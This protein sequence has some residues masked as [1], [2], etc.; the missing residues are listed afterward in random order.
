V[1]IYSSSRFIEHTPPPGHPERPERGE[2]FEAVAAEHRRRGGVVRDPRPATREELARVHTPAYLDQ[3]QATAGRA[4]MLDGDT[5]TSP[6][7]H[8]VALLA[9]GATIEAAR[10][11]RQARK[12]TIAMVRPPGHHAEADQAMGFCLYNNVA[13]AAAALRADGVA[14]VAIIDID[15][16]HGN[17]TQHIFY[18]DPAVLYVSSHQYPYYPGTGAADETGEGPGRGATLNLPM[19]A[20]TRDDVF[21]AAY[22]KAVVPALEAFK[23]E[24]L[25]VSA[26]FDAHELDPLGGL[27]VTTAGYMTVAALLTGAA[28]RL[29]GGRIAFVTEGGYHLSALQE[30]LT[31]LVNVVAK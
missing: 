16:H 2:V 6:E 15:V 14:R 26:G 3:I 30:C 11:A 24:V 19:A 5:F 7:S 12:P 17:G 20:G 28:A 13:V 21:I 29:A 9:A 10:E 27:R 25:L 4:A 18:R 1:I 22:E 8:E 31:E 23:P